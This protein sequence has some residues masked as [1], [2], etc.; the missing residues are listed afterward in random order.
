[1]IRWMSLL[2]ALTLASSLGAATPARAEF[3]PDSTMERLFA[4]AQDSALAPAAEA[5]LRRIERAVADDEVP[6][7]RHL[8]TQSLITQRIPVPALRATVDSTF[9]QRGDRFPNCAMYSWMVVEAFLERGE[10]F[11]YADS[12]AWARLRTY[13]EER[14]AQGERQWSGLL[15]RLYNR[16]DRH[17]STIALLA[18]LADSSPD[19]RGL[20]W[21]LGVAYERAGRL[22]RAL[23]EFLRHGAVFGGD[24]APGERLTSVY[25]QHHGGLDGLDA[26]FAAALA[27]DRQRVVFDE[28]RVDRAAPAWRL[29][30]PEGRTR[31][32]AE[33][34]GRPAV[35]KFWGT[36]CGPCIET[37]PEFI[38][39]SRDP[40]W[41]GVRF[42]TIDTEYQGGPDALARVA[43]M[44]RERGWDI[45]V[46]VDTTSATARA[47]GVS[48]FPSLVL[49]DA[50]G[51]MRFLDEP[52]SRVREM[53]EAQLAAMLGEPRPGRKR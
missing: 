9:A 10:E 33:L 22:D 51:R 7:V 52:H 17:D 1:M 50:G 41:Q 35:I 48:V 5:E 49:I 32:S 46:A 39:M 45:P 24:S 25:R 6:L 16:F 30:T 2:S 29:P 28:R 18:P 27:A 43:R 14:D 3:P 4:A 31:R 37:M 19:D 36:W 20:H 47:F 13:R 26:R 38:E 53:A 42:T 8:L 44:C 23:E 15:G 12:L 11:A 40:R 34:A 21:A